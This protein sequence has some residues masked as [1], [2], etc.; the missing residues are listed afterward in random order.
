MILCPEEVDEKSDPACQEDNYDGND[1]AD[2]RNR[3]LDDVEHGEYGKYYAGDV[4]DFAHEIGEL[5]FSCTK[6]MNFAGKFMTNEKKFT[7]GDEMSK[8]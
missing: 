7:F 1:L 8:L 4:D 5:S 3:F 2:Q 6:L